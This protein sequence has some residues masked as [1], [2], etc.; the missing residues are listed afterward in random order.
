MTNSPLTILIIAVIGIVAYIVTARALADY[1]TLGYPR[2]I[3]AAVS[4]IGCIGLMQMDTGII[5]AVLLPASALLIAVC[6]ML[7]V[8]VFFRF[9]ANR[10]GRNGPLPDKQSLKKK[11]S[12]KKQQK[13]KVEKKRRIKTTG[14]KHS[15]H[16]KSTGRGNSLS[17][18][19]SASQ[20]DS[21]N[22][23]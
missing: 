14:D 8:T 16:V 13:I 17:S 5:T 10:L 19:Q 18:A 2:I 11:K 15:R 12:P 6:L 4:L 1:S 3:A 23:W 9:R 22:P 7:A 21:H 20:T